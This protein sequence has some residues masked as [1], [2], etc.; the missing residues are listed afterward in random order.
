[1]NLKQA[2]LLALHIAGCFCLFPGFVGESRADLIRLK[3]GGEVRGKLVPEESPYP[4]RIRIKTVSGSTVS[5]SSQE[6]EFITRRSATYEEYEIQARLT[7]HDLESLWKLSQWCQEKRLNTQREKHLHHILE[8]APEN[9]QAHKAL[10]HVQRGGNWTT[11]EQYMQSR[12]YVRYRGKY[13]TP[14]E[15]NLLVITEADREKQQQW[16]SKIHLW[17]KWL[18][19]QHEKQR[20]QAEANIKTVNDP[21]A[22]PALKKI[23]ASQ[24]SRNIRLLYV[25]TLAHIDSPSSAAALVEQGITDADRG[26]RQR[27]IIAIPESQIDQANEI[28]IQLLAHKENVIVRRAATALNKLGGKTA[29]PHLIDSLV[30]T[31]QYRIHADVPAPGFTTE[32]GSNG[33]NSVPKSSQS[34][35]VSSD[36][37][38]D[39]LSNPLASSNISVHGDAPHLQK[40]RTVRVNQKNPEVLEALKSLTKTNFG[41]DERTWKLWWLSQN[42]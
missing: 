2:H 14:E 8:L 32:S 16:H 25:E 3:H 22:V 1:M 17:G 20:Q 29:I 15:K 30:T 27:A 41:Y 31:H 11:H 24:A 18:T 28:L 33:S 6:V 42:S 10:G 9:E 35:Q 12:G 21:H 13:I 26:I 34:P 7:P 23:F 4:N 39:L 36:V 37:I 5:V 19:G 40:I 38:A